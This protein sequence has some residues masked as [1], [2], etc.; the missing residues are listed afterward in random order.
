MPSSS[1]HANVEPRHTVSLRRSRRRRW[2]FVA[3]YAAAAVLPVGLYALTSSGA[4]LPRS[5]AL[6]TATSGAC[7][8]YTTTVAGSGPRGL[9]TG[10]GTEA[11]F[12]S[13]QGLAVDSAG[14]IYLAD[15]SEASVIREITADGTVTSFVGR[16]R[17]FSDGT[18]DTALLH[19]PS[20]MAVDTVGNVY[21][22]DVNIHR[23]RRITPDGT[24]TTIAGHAVRLG[25]AGGFADGMGTAALFNNPS[26]VALDVA[27]NLYVADTGNNRIRKITPKGVVTT[28]AGSTEG[29][30]DGIGSASYFRH[31]TGLAVDALGHLYVSDTGNLRIRK[32]RP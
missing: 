12:Y 10:T 27:G 11:E 17:G 2:R 20:G 4:D 19:W 9:A 32:I 15:S 29:F 13:P 21:V 23:I 18:G 26:G 7:P 30:A 5:G 24:V 6:I 8:Y 16:S 1:D 22:A 14:T 25:G 28:I 3:S 31:P